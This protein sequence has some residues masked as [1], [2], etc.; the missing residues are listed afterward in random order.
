MQT[1]HKQVQQILTFSCKQVQQVHNLDSIRLA[2]NICA[3][4]ECIVASTMES[5]LLVKSKGSNVSS[6][7]RRQ[8][9]SEL[10][11]RD[12]Q[13]GIHGNNDLR[14]M[15]DSIPSLSSIVAA[16]LDQETEQLF[17][18]ANR[19]LTRPKS[20]SLKEKMSGKL[21]L[22]SK[23]NRQAD[24][25]VTDSDFSRLLMR[26]HPAYTL[27]NDAR[28]FLGAITSELILESLSG[29]AA[30]FSS[31]SSSSSSSL[32]V[33]GAIGAKSKAYAKVVMD[34]FSLISP[35]GS[36]VRIIFKA[37]DSTVTTAI[38]KLKAPRNATL[39]SVLDRASSKLKATRKN[40]TYVYNGRPLDPSSTPDKLS[41]DSS[42]QPIHIFAVPKKWW[43]FKQRE[44]ARKGLLTSLK[45]IDVKELIGQAKSKV[46]STTDV[47][48]RTYNTS[49]TRRSSSS[50]LSSLSKTSNHEPASEDDPR[51]THSSTKLRK[52]KSF[53]KR[54][55][56][57]SLPRLIR[58]PKN[59]T[60]PDLSELDNIPIPQVEAF[61]ESAQRSLRK[62]PF[63]PV[64][65]RRSKKDS[66]KPGAKLRA[67]QRKELR[68]KG[69]AKAAQ[70]KL[71]RKKQRQKKEQNAAIQIQSKM[72]QYR[73]A[74]VVENKRNEKK[75]AYERKRNNKIKEFNAAGKNSLKESRRTIQAWGRVKRVFQDLPQWI[76]HLELPDGF[77]DGGEDSQLCL[78]QARKLRALL[79]DAEA[80]TELFQDTA[81]H[82]LVLLEKWDQDAKVQSIPSMT[83]QQLREDTEQRQWETKTLQEL[84]NQ[85]EQ[86]DHKEQQPQ[87]P[88]SNFSLVNMLVTSDRTGEPTSTDLPAITA[89]ANGTAADTVVQ[90]QPEPQLEEQNRPEEHAKECKQ[91][92]PQRTNRRRMKKQL[93]TVKEE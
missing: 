54:S 85:R 58:S 8:K 74:R 90:I 21:P 51:F 9:V 45:S 20:A 65:H 91:I 80:Q 55:N 12:L 66:S 76:T 5:A 17:V 23:W 68:R 47:K 27:S 89:A 1:N 92:L 24:A 52:P 67:E 78:E 15:C 37:I 50:S 25:A 70:A 34:R 13:L 56:F 22:A 84:R 29:T 40:T 62:S 93:A 32:I 59:G 11:S 57:K 82:T 86:R 64:R 71:R 53:S 72:R 28:L 87:Q 2:V 16:Y 81:R 48:K 73:D 46:D 30:S 7:R 10:T 49:S 31:S 14:M 39:S 63:R 6:S 69:T 42:V 26:T 79:C 88:A 41:M 83:Q 60:R 3:K 35:K 33:G 61:T 75:Q 18:A 77:E 4:V 43:I 36:T 19:V 44:Q 38:C